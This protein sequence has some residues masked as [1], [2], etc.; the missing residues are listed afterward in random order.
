[1]A[2]TT[3]ETKTDYI[4]LHLDGDFVGGEET[5]NLRTVLKHLSEGEHTKLMIDFTNTVYLASPTLGVL[6]SAN[7]QFA[8]KKGKIVFF[9]VSEYLDN[10]FTI[11]KLT[12]IFPICQTFEEAKKELDVK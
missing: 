12:L 5:D 3:I 7:A 10:I 2:Q 8:K 6:L 9:N 4:I 1:M 11:T